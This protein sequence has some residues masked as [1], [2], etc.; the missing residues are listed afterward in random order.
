ML[1]LPGH[2]FIEYDAIRLH[3]LTETARLDLN[4]DEIQIASTVIAKR[5][6]AF[7]RNTNSRSFLYINNLSIYLKLALAANE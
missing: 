3:P 6:F 5:T 1:L 2:R 4:D 7:R